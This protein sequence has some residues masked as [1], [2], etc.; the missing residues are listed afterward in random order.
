MPFRIAEVP[1][2]YVYENGFGSDF[3]EFNFLEE[4]FEKPLRKLLKKRFSV[5][6]SILNFEQVKA[7]IEQGKVNGPLGI[8]L[9]QDKMQY[10]FLYESKFY[11]RGSLVASKL[12]ASKQILSYLREEKGLKVPSG[13]RFVVRLP[14]EQVFEGIQEFNFFKEFKE[15]VTFYRFFSTPSLKAHRFG[16]ACNLNDYEEENRSE[17]KKICIFLNKR[18]E[19]NIQKIRSSY[20]QNLL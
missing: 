11:S 7:L 8:Y 4:G 10:E 16:R 18:S 14:K 15:M 5:A 2:I 3:V 19:K 20:V 13:T 12:E 9:H 6:S 17:S 1:F